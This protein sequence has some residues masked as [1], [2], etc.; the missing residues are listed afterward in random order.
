MSR[1]NATIGSFVSV[2]GY[3]SNVFS[4]SDHG[5]YRWIGTV[6]EIKK[7][8]RKGEYLFLVERA[9]GKAAGQREWVID[10]DVRLY[11]RS[12]SDTK[13]EAVQ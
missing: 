9:K 2:G 4:N 13:G 8:E 11:R 1:R 5:D 7:G 6:I 3:N 10:K 12:S